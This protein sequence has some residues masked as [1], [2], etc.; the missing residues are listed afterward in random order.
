MVDLLFTAD[1]AI[2]GPALVPSRLTRATISLPQ[3]YL[4]EGVQA[5]VC[6]IQE[7]GPHQVTGLPKGIEVETWTGCTIGPPKW[8]LAAVEATTSAGRWLGTR[9]SHYAGIHGH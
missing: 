4:V 3:T 6:I 2:V 5:V 9:M 1:W 8:G 7:N